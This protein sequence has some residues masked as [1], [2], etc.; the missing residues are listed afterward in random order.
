MFFAYQAADYP[1]YSV[2]EMASQLVPVGSQYRDNLYVGFGFAFLLLPLVM[3]I[4]SEF[5]HRHHLDQLDQQRERLERIWL[6]SAK[7]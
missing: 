1:R 7:K 6:M 2:T 3:A 5:W 4:A